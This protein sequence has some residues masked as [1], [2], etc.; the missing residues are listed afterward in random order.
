[1]MLEL[2]VSDNIVLTYDL[3]HNYPNRRSEQ[4]E[5][6]MVDRK[7]NSLMTM[8]RLTSRMHDTDVMIAW[9]DFRSIPL[10]SS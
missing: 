4:K 10:E 7:K 8:E 3:L 1:M 2:F 5:I 6:V 9:H